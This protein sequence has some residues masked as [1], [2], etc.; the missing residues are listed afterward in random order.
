M[1]AGLNCDKCKLHLKGL[2]T[3]FACGI[4][5]EDHLGGIPIEDVSRNEQKLPI[6]ITKVSRTNRRGKNL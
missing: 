4:C 5:M 2:R 6:T 1:G 3:A